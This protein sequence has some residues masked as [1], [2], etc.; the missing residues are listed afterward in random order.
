MLAWFEPDEAHSRPVPK[1]G[2][3]ETKLEI[4]TTES[5]SIAADV[6]QRRAPPPDGF[7]PLAAR[8][9]TTKLRPFTRNRVQ[10]SR[11]ETRTRET[12]LQPI[13]IERTVEDGTL[14]HPP[15][16]PPWILILSLVPNAGAAVAR[17]ADAAR[18]SY[19]SIRELDII[20]GDRRPAPRDGTMRF[21]VAKDSSAYEATAPYFSSL[22][23]PV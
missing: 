12:I 1:R 3:K 5:G 10:A 16:L 14:C 21:E 15:H 17:L 20:A 8:V 13:S 19:L 18:F 11:T 23:C 4:G 22:R 7:S 2:S 9:E 6:F